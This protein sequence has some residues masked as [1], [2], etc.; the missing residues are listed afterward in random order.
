MTAEA[1]YGF[2]WAL[3]NTPKT[4]DKREIL[5]GHAGI[6]DLEKYL[7]YVHDEVN[8]VWGK[9]KLPTIAA[10]PVDDTLQDET[11]EEMYAM[12]EKMNDGELKGNAADAAM[13]DYLAGKKP[14][15]EQLLFYVLKRDIKA[16]TGAK[17]INEEMGRFIPIAPYMR[18]EPE[19]QMTNRIVYET[20]GIKH[21]ALAQSKADG[22]FLNSRLS[23]GYDDVECTT[24]YGRE[25][26]SNKFLNSLSIIPGLM[27][28]GKDFV[29]H[30]ELLLKDTDGTIMDRQTG[31]G[32]INAYAKRESTTAEFVK[33]IK[34]AKTE[35]AKQKLI[36][37]LEEHILEW[38][39]IQKN[40]VYEVWDLV[41]YNDWINLECD[42]MTFIRFNMVNEAVVKYNQY[43]ESIDMDIDNC[44]LRLID[45][46][47]VY[48]EDEAMSFYQEQLDKGLEGMVIKNMYATWKHDTNREGIIKLKDFKENDLI[49]L[50]W[51]PADEDSE[52]VGGIGSL[53]C[54][55]SE[56]ILKVNVSGM[57]RH[58]R[59][60]ERVDEK[61]S[62]KGL[63]VIDG[64]DFDQFTGKIAAVKYNEMTKNK[65]TGVYSLF[66][67]SILEIR[68]PGDK[69]QAD[70]FEK[71]KKDSKYKGK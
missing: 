37:K 68:D 14:Y 42:I 47:V 27:N 71:I 24:R 66:L 49:I 45:Y 43:V 65:D 28:F 69:T 21:G 32:K 6:P 60:L 25:V 15:Y 1:I 52:F 11:L 54:E 50:G 57:K 3:Q 2:I 33:K 5:R 41:A 17:M 16:K 9:S 30:G 8:F 58:Q 64:F 36:D 34:A 51:E 56:G 61:D 53:I 59:G 39:Y 18:C 35:K 55:S 62:S 38:D 10:T 26:P 31:N 12:L 70:D 48:N 7:R 46:K 44:E 29:M 13:Q 67:P 23:P 22:A 40:L 20:D 19:A 4:N 63:K